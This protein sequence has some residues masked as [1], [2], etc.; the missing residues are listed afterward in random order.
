MKIKSLH[1]HKVKIPFPGRDPIVFLP[2]EEKEIENLEL[3]IKIA[4]QKGFQAP[5]LLGKPTENF[6][7]VGIKQKS[8]KKGGD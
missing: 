2:K 6:G 4:N 8:R 7:N 1:E 5:E 3:A